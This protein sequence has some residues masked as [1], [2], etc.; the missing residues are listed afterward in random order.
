MSTAK[1]MS[2]CTLWFP[3]IPRVI[4]EMK[5]ARFDHSFWLPGEAETRDGCRSHDHS[6]V[7]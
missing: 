1:K 2:L 5:H 3:V 6:R 4:M 7:R